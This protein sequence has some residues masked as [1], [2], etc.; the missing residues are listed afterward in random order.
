MEINQLLEMDNL[1]L[2]QSF[3]QSN[4]RVLETLDEDGN[5]LLILAFK[6]NSSDEIIQFLASEIDPNI[7]NEVGI[8]PLFIAIQKGRQNWVEN[9]LEL[10]ISPSETERESGFTPLM[11]AIVSY[12]DDIAKLLLEKGAEKKVRDRHGLTALDY[13]RKM[14]RSDLIDLLSEN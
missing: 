11:E 9:F 3:V 1:H 12:Q 8:T 4:H 14:R 6:K 13:A 10:G 2:L 7:G 5:N